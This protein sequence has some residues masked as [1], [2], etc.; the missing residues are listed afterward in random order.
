MLKQ[1]TKYNQPKKESFFG[2]L[3][4]GMAQAYLQHRYQQNTSG[5]V[6]RPGYSSGGGIPVYTPD[7]CV[8]AV[9]AGKCHGS[10][11]PK[12]AYRKKCYG[13]MVH[14]KCTGPMF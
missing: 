12:K 10:I 4:K 2:K 7:E 11:T 9:V 5:Y 8:G 3:L 1:A 14:G 6:S 13:Q